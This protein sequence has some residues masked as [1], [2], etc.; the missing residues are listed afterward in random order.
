MR[1]ILSRI[2]LIAPILNVIISLHSNYMLGANIAS[3]W[4]ELENETSFLSPVCC[5]SHYETEHLEETQNHT[6]MRRLQESPLPSTNT[7]IRLK[8]N[9]TVFSSFNVLMCV[10]KDK[11]LVLMEQKRMC[12]PKVISSL[13]K[14]EGSAVN[15]TKGDAN[16]VGVIPPVLMETTEI[17]NSMVI[18]D[19][20][21]NMFEAV[22]P[23]KPL[24]KNTKAITV[25]IDLASSKAG[26][27]VH[28][29]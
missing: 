4:K 9:N 29:L 10:M 18:V 17:P 1:P 15:G 12:Y 7:G 22:E 8:S 13:H 23:I 19:M 5:S 26:N 3:L 14:K 16:R 20:Q 6:A 24:Q 25:R 27:P 11:E 21:D 2:G 28:S